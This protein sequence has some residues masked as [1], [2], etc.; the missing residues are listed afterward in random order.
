MVA[1][2]DLVTEF[3]RAWADPRNTAIDL[4]PVDVNKVLRDRYDVD[5]DLVYTRTM[6]WDMETR[7]ASAP[8]FYIP[9]VVR[10]GSA[11]KWP[12]EDPDRFTRA[13]QQRLWLDPDEFGLII[14]HVQLG[15]AEQSIWFIGDTGHTTPDGH[16]LVAD[17]RQPL[18]HVRHWVDG[19]ENEPLNRWRILHLTNRPDQQTIDFFAELGQNPY[20]RDFIEVHIREVLGYRLTR[21]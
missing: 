13:S 2:V 17:R 15:R 5:R 9:S 10:P 11:R 16:E 4:P 12:S 14:E 6:M 19:D 3:E 18:F 20:L 8:D 7:K 21:K 1:S